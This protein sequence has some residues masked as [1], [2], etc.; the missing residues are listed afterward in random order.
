[1]LVDVDLSDDEVAGKCQHEGLQQTSKCCG[2]VL[3][4]SR[5]L[6]FSHGPWVSLAN[7]YRLHLQYRDIYCL[8]NTNQQLVLL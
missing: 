3:Y 2:L 6:G 7:V 1:V 8:T 4:S 5:G